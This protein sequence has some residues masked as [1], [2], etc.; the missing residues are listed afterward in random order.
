MLQACYAIVTPSQG[1]PVPEALERL[2]AEVVVP[3]T[4]RALKRA[5]ARGEDLPTGSGGSDVYAGGAGGAGGEGGE[6]GAGS[7][8]GGAAADEDGGD[9]EGAAGDAPFAAALP[10]RRKIEGKSAIAKL[11]ATAPSGEGSTKAGTTT[12]ASAPPSAP[13]GKSIGTSSR[14]EAP[15]DVK[16]P[17]NEAFNAPRGRVVPEHMLPMVAAPAPE[18]EPPAHL[19][20][21]E[22][23][24]WYKAQRIGFDA[25]ATAERRREA[26]D[27]P[28]VAAPQLGEP[29]AVP[30]GADG[31]A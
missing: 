23:K 13:I 25:P 3:K 15:Q 29:R 8:D 24:K 11:A 12:R 31:S 10:K 1:Q 19:S 14:R 4:R 18:I 22:R 28:S 27:Q 26:D 17:P 21:K 20:K 2:K 9:G 5:R 6:G 16:K 7:G 30:D